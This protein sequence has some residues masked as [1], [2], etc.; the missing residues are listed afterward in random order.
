MQD[1]QTYMTQPPLN[2]IK[3][4]FPTQYANTQPFAVGINADITQEE[5]RGLW[6]MPPI[7]ICSHILGMMRQPPRN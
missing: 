4:W 6:V 5:K 1:S 3:T 2:P 7:Y